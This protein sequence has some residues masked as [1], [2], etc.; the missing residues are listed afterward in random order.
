M[1]EPNYKKIVDKLN[2][3]LNKSIN[4]DFTHHAFYYESNY[5]ID[6]IKFNDIILWDSEND[7]RDFIMTDRGEV[8]E[9]LYDYVKDVFDEYVNE[10]NNIEL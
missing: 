8:K 3:K 2:D 7:G 10:L 4:D 1:N 6:A 5:A 9:D